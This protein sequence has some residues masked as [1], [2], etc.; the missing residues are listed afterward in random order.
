MVLLKVAKRNI[1]K[2]IACNWYRSES[3][4]VNSV[5][6]R[7]IVLGKISATSRVS[8]PIIEAFLLPKFHFPP[9]IKE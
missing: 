6:S 5:S 4:H 3:S 8:D 1:T 9:R 2:L 7:M